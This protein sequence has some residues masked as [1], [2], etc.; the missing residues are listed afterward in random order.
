MLFQANSILLRSYIIPLSVKMISFSGIALLVLVGFGMYGCPQYNVYHSRLSGEAELANAQY[1]RQV[2]VQ[3]AQA[4]K[5]AAALLAESEVI[6][7]GGVAQANKIIGDSLKGNEAYLKW[8]WIDKLD[9]SKQ[10]TIYVPTET[11]MPIM[12]AGKNKT[13]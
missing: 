8:L 12:E 5:D 11:G 10:S 9:T 13:E 1:S 7:A 2:A 4:K 3:E 6:R